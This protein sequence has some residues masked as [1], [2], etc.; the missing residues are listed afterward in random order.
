MK[1]H[2]WLAY[3]VGGTVLSVG[4][5]ASGSAA[6]IGLLTQVVGW[7]SVVI[8]SVIALRS[9]RQE[10]RPWIFFALAAAAF[11]IAGLVRTAYGALIGVD[12]PFPSPGDAIALSGHLLLICG[13]IL[14]GHLR[15]PDRNR[16]AILDGAIIAVALQTVVWAALLWPY[17]TDVSF[18]LDERTI[19]AGYALMTMVVLATVGRLAI[20]PGARTL[21]YRLLA[22]AVFVIFVQDITVTLNTVGQSTAGIKE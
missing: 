7:S 8:G 12:S 19:N 15:S 9:R 21:S 18:P 6:L 10:G 5:G 22:A 2:G 11:L 16:A 14:L 3:L 13:S 17:M 1:T 4:A 20:G